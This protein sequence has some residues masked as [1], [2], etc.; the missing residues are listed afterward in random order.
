MVSTQRWS[1]FVGVA[2]LGAVLLG[3]GA[4]ARAQDVYTGNPVVK[5]AKEAFPAVVNIDTE[6]MVTR[7]PFPFGDDPFFRE[8]FG[9]Q[10]KRFSDIVPMRGAGSGFLVTEDGYILT[11]NHVVAEAD[12]ITPGAQK[13]H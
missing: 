13:P 2:V 7:S 8:F 12:K 9:E 10:G 1:L 4:E 3:L 11:N 6:K 5:I